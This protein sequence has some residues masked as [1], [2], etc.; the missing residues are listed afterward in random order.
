MLTIDRMYRLRDISLFLKKFKYKEPLTKQV[1]VDFLQESLYNDAIAISQKSIQRD[2]DLLKKAYRAPIKWSPKKGFY[3]TDPEWTYDFELDTIDSGQI[4]ALILATEL[5]A[6]YKGS[7]MVCLLEQLTETARKLCPENPPEKLSKTDS[8]VLKGRLHLNRKKQKGDPLVLASQAYELSKKGCYEQALELAALA[9]E[10]SPN[11]PIALSARVLICHGMDKHNEVLQD[12]DT[13]LDI[14]KKSPQMAMSIRD[15]AYRYRTHAL[16]CLY[17]YKDAIKAA[18]LGL[19]LSPNDPELLAKTAFCCG[20]SHEYPT[21]IQYATR[22]LQIS[23]ENLLALHTRTNA[24]YISHEFD[25]AIQDANNLLEQH[26][27]GIEVLDLRAAAYR[28]S[29]RYENAIQDATSS[30]AIY[31]KNEKALH[32]RA[33]AYLRIG[34]YEDAILDAK[35]MLKIDPENESALKIIKTAELGS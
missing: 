1:I 22:S 12:T 5:L 23:P 2:L 29:G 20:A 16:M 10:S 21:A 3:L 4:K 28:F 33:E 32:T 11:N 24:Y 18:E 35:R 6:S 13:L 26:P 30:L 34:R 14:A 7:P 31:P 17:R 15:L 25:L 19:K 9:L 27:G 8:A